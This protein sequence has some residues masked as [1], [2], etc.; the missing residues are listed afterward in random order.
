VEKIILLICDRPQ[1]WDTSSESYKDKHKTRDGWNEVC[2]E[3][4]DDFDNKDSGE[5][6]VIGKYL[7]YFFLVYNILLITL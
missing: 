7:Y 5:K 2:S 4:F 6:A 3:L 1:L